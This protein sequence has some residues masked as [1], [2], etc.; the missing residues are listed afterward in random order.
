MAAIEAR[1]DHNIALAQRRF[2]PVTIIKLKGGSHD[3]M[4]QLLAH[5]HRETFDFIYVDGSH[6]APDV[7]GDLFLSMQ[8]CRIGGVIAC[9]D[10][11][12]GEGSENI[13]HRPKLGVD[14][15]T[16]C[17]AGRLKVLHGF[18]LYQLYMTKVGR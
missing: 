11:L 18:S 15:F 8:L 3:Q 1:F 5:G 16:T 14:A 12:W 10:Y 13:L 4:I 7:L 2:A 9:D 6:Q 17:F